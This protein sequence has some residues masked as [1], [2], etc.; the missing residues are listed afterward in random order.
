VALG[1]MLK[2][3]EAG[4]GAGKHREGRSKSSEREENAST[5]PS[6]L[7]LPSLPPSLPPSDGT[8]TDV[9][10][11]GASPRRKPDIPSTRRW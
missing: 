3:G 7:Y 10:P 11:T 1:A 4:E 2:E 9:K 5:S 8:V 6:P